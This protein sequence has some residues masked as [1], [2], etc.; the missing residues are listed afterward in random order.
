MLSDLYEAQGNIPFAYTYY[1]NASASRD[2]I[3]NIDK[4]TS[5]NN[6]LDLYEK[7]SLQNIIR[8]RQFDVYVTLFVCILSILICAFFIYRYIRQIRLNKELVQRNQEYLKRSEM[9]RMYLKPESTQSGNES[10]DEVLFGKLE[11]IMR[12]EHA[13][14]SND[15]SLDKLA[16][17][18]GTNR[19]YISR[20]INRYADKSFWGYVNMYRIAEATEILSDLDKDVQIKNIYESLGYNSAASF[21]RVFR[22]ETGISPSKYR[23]EV[24]K[25]KPRA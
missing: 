7:A 24:R 23:E 12:E 18:L 17:M 8:K 11:R 14:R 20:V 3:M 1:K 16:S 21:F 4:E 22:E 10:A 15:I 5:F 25:I 19:T 9:L 6:L 2:S 13:Y